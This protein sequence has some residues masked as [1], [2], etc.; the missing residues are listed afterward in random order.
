MAVQNWGSVPDWLAAV[1]TIAAVAY[2]LRA[3][4]RDH[5]RLETE[6]REAAADRRLFRQE[7]AQQAMAARRRLAAQVTLV[8]GRTL[9][10]LE[11]GLG[12]EG[13]AVKWQVHNGGDEP[14]SLV[15]LVQRPVPSESEAAAPEIADFWPAIEAGGSREIY[16]RLYGSN[17]H[18]NREV[19]FTD[20]TGARWQ[21]KTLGGLRELLPDDP[22]MVPFI[23]MQA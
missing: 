15:A 13:P 10:L 4:F 9:V 2:A 11:D 21:R 18:P 16:T 22:E 8:A 17:Y 5:K 23:A 6:R 19:Q 14:I 7:Q 20:G 12:F 1:G 3:G